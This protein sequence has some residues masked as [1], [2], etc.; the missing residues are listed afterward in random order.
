MATM[1]PGGVL[2]PLVLTGG[3]LVAVL[4]ALFWQRR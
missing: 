1:V 4:A 2:L 3:V